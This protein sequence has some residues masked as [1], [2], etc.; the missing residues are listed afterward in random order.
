M[1]NTWQAWL[2]AGGVLFIL[3]LFTPGFVAA[4]FGGACL[5]T[6][7]P[8]ALGAPLWGMMATFI[9]STLGI[10][11]GVRP[12]FVRKQSAQRARTNADALVGR[13]GKVIE[14]IDNQSSNGRILVEGDDW[15]AVSEGD[16]TIAVGERVI[17]KRIESN[18]L[19]VSRYTEI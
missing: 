16:E 15:R 1:N 10:A 18:R 19:H 2:I 12:F 11:I 14:G 13:I 17:V 5:V 6:A 8:A 4:V 9:V 7:I 3:E